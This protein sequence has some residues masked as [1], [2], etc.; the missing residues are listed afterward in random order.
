MLLDQAGHLV[1][2]LRLETVEV[3]VSCEVLTLWLSLSLTLSSHTGNPNMIWYKWKIM[4]PERRNH[5]FT[6]L[7]FRRPCFSNAY[8]T[9]KT[10]WMK[11]A[12][13]LAKF[14][15][16][17]LGGLCARVPHHP[18]TANFLRNFALKMMMA[19][20]MMVMR[21]N[22]DV[23]STLSSSPHHRHLDFVIFSAK[24]RRKFAVLGWWG[25][26]AHRPPK[27]NVRNMARNPTIFV[28]MAINVLR[29]LPNI[30][31]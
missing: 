23:E 24:F 15:T 2:S 5:Q 22:H 10:I 16:L 31:F 30:V 26:R 4:I 18:N 1:A 7:I 27:R 6:L 13:F 20:M 11:I 17:R 25:S 12:E 19:L 3:W 14:Q 9:F 21:D 29:N 8:F 28:E